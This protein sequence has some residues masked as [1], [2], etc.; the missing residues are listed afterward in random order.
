MISEDRLLFIKPVHRASPTPIL[1]YITRKMAAAFRRASVD[2]KTYLGWH[3][4]VCGA[5]SAARN[6]YIPSGQLINS[7]CVHYVAYH[8]SEI[9]AQQ[10][11]IIE[12]LTSEEV[13]PSEDELKGGRYQRSG[14]QRGAIAILQGIGGA[15]TH[16]HESWAAWPLVRKWRQFWRG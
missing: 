10:F 1:D 5:R 11:A 2:T 4:C 12:T 15:T 16:S 3:E 7:L 14:T 8:R 6:Y 9:P 13:Q